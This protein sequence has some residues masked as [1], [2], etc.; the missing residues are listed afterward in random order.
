MLAYKGFLHRWM[1]YTAKLAP[2]T[3]E[4]IMPLLMS[5]TKAAVAQCTGG[6]NGRQC[7]FHWTSGKFDNLLGVGQQMNVLGALSSLLALDAP[8][9]VTNKTGGTSMGDPNAG[10]DR[11]TY[12]QLGP[13]TTGDR[14]GA[15]ILTVVAV[16]LASVS[17][18]WMLK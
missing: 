17:L 10:S 13:I 14:A 8:V 4:R 9:P 6:D 3:A 11:P 1:A 5:S 16:A 7:G 2:S 18:W 15:G 12:D